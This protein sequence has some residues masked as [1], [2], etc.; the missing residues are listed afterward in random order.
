M[1]FCLSVSVPCNHFLPIGHQFDL[2]IEEEEGMGKTRAN[3]FSVTEKAM[4]MMNK[5]GGW[6]S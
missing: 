6:G 4:Q 5:R 1:F 3:D 2:T